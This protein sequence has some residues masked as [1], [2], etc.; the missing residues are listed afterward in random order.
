MYYLTVLEVRSSISVSLAKIKILAGLFP[1]GDSR[2]E[3]VSLSFPASNATTFFGSCLLPS[4]SKSAGYC[5]PSSPTC[6]H[7]F[8]SYF[9]ILTPLPPFHKDPCGYSGPTHIIQDNLLIVKILNLS[10][11][12]SF[13]PCKVTHSQVPGI[14]A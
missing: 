5:F 3:S 10:I 6:S 9:L 8:F 14:R 4:F 11:R 13:S 2:K 1:S 12:K 7:P